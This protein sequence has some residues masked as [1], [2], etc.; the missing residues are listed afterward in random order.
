MDGVP[1]LHGTVRALA[2][3]GSSPLRWERD[4]LLWVFP[5]TGIVI[6]HFNDV[7]LQRILSTGD[8]RKGWLDDSMPTV[9]QFGEGWVEASAVAAA[10][11][12]GSA[13]GAHRFAQRSALALEGLA[14]AGVYAQIFKYAVWSNR[15]YEDMSAHRYFA[16]DQGTQ[17]MPSGHTF[18]AFAVAEIYGSEYGRA[19]T[20]PFAALVA[21]SRVYNQA[22]WPT[23][24]AVGAILGVLVGRQLDAAARKD[25]PPLFRLSVRNEGDAP[26]L[27]L[28]RRF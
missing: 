2:H 1:I 21:Y 27:M 25:G 12:L 7:D 26:L 19:Y 18:S 5:I 24:V 6:L 10:W 3:F 22:H 11:G 8:A 28:S 9:S 17:G 16:Y 4:D 20:Y 15:P 23:D 14:V 13:F